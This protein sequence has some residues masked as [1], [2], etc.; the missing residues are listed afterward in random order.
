MK[1][2]VCKGFFS[3]II[4]GIDLVRMKGGNCGFYRI[5]W[6]IIK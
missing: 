6:V 3:Y 4:I 2:G 5:K 1:S